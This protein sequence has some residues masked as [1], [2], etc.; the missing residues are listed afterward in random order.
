MHV[1]HAMQVSL[2]KCAMISPLLLVLL[3]NDFL[4]KR[5]IFFLVKRVAPPDVI[6]VST[7]KIH[8]FVDIPTNRYIFLG[9]AII[10]IIR[11]DRL[12]ADIQN[13]N[14]DFGPEISVRIFYLYLTECSESEEEKAVIS[15]MRCVD[16]LPEN[17]REVGES[18]TQRFLSRPSGHRFIDD[19][20][21]FG[22]RSGNSLSVDVLWGTDLE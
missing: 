4:V 11:F 13:E 15:Q 22:R 14:V 19:P 7:A 2:I 6:L 12:I 21:L 16:M 8:L 9:P 18:T 5:Y 3:L 20:E 1:P 17:L 10:Q